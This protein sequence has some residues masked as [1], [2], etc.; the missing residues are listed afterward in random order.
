[1]RRRL[2]KS[3]L[4]RAVVTACDLHYEGSITIDAGLLERADILA[5]EQV[6][7]VDI[8][9]GTR[10][11][12]YAIPGERGSMTVQVNG[13]AARLVYPGDL[14]IVMS[15]ADLDECEVPTHHPVIVTL[16]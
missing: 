3:K 5:F 11:E 16:P 8:N 14:I 2:L 13:A 7:V 10:F 4:H 9:N 1:M 15:F 12:T 6:Q